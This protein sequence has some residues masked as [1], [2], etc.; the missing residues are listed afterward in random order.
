MASDD[1]RQPDVRRLREQDL[2]RILDD[3][4]NIE[5]MV[6]AIRGRVD[7]HRIAAAGHSWGAQTA[8]TLLGAR[9]LDPANG[10]TV[11]IYDPRVK[12]GVLLAVPG[13]GGANLAPA[14]AQKFPFMQPDFSS[15]TTPTLV[16]AGGDVHNSMTVR[17]PDWWRE[18]YDLSPGAKALFTALG[19]QHSLG[20]IPNYEAKETTDENPA[21]VAAIQRLSTAFLHAV[22]G[23]DTDRWSTA[24]AEEQARNQPQGSVENK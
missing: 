3:L 21:R 24:V 20:G 17:G 6:P 9:H 15:L 4:E 7:R 13:T 22:L 16:V 19:G 5:E 23:S 1:P 14:V 2:V 11:S 8:S 10:S 12:A 18:A